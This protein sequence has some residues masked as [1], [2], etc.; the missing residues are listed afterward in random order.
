MTNSNFFWS[1]SNSKLNKT[2]KKW[3]ERF[4]KAASFRSFNIP[5]L[6]SETGMKTCPYAGSC[7]DICYAGQGRMNFSTARA[8]RERN[9]DHITSITPRELSKE[10]V[11]DVNR[12]R[13]V[14]HIRIHDSGD[15]FSRAYY[16]AW[17][18]TAVECSDKIFYAYTKSIPF[19]EWDSHPKNF[20]VVQSVGG[21]RNKDID[22]N[23]SH[24]KIFATEAERKKAG[25]C[26]GNVSDIPA[27]LGQKKIGLVYHGVKNLTEDN[28]I[29]LRV[30]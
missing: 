22:L 10:L 21:K 20:R 24:A 13:A 7:A 15:F 19:L 12:M 6:S 11:D 30:A 4:G 27:I 28:L 14:T 29:Q 25:Y 1:K 8:A 3:T 23:Y 17:V 5:R 16:R 9:L 18:R 2:A 26:D